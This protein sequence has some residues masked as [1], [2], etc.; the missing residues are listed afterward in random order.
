[1]AYSDTEISTQD[2]NALS[3]Y[4][5][6][7][8]Q[9]HWRYTN[10]DRAIDR[11]EES[12]VVTYEPRAVSDDGM[13][14][15]G[16]TANDFTMSAPSDLPIVAL[17]RGTPPSE[18]IRLVVRR[19]HLG[20][21]ETPIY[22]IGT[23]SNVKRG[24]SPAEAEIVGQ[25]LAASFRRTG[26]RL[27]WT[28]ECPHFLY[29]TQCR[30]DPE[31]YVVPAVVQV[32]TGNTLT[33]DTVGGKPDDWF[34]G[35][36]VTWIADLDS[37]TIERRMVEQQT[38]TLLTIFGLTDRLAVGQQVKAYPGC[39]RTPDVCESKYDN[40]PN[41]GGFQYMPGESPFEGNIF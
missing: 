7:W 14:Q 38:G 3:L 31:A 5:L 1:M 8:G 40:I 29:D 35:G 4:H 11:L 10:A 28:K 33:L 39:N 18:T 12:V 13:V 41:Y 37:G 23:V 6:R 34:K 27:C 15:G 17:F 26:L 9:T 20:E 24:S 32:L 36:F 16:S 19:M 22:W 2:G 21:D 30:V 25:P